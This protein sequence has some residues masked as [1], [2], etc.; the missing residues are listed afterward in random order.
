MA[1]EPMFDDPN[2]KLEHQ[3]REQMK[4]GDAWRLESTASAVPIGIEDQLDRLGADVDLDDGERWRMLD[5]GRAPLAW[6]PKGLLL[7]TMRA[8]SGVGSEVKAGF[9]ETR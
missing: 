1:T 8:G 3:A 5:V 6:L 4:L 7:V 9:I 2:A